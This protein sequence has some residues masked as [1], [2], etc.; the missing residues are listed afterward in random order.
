[1]DE[2]GG[3]VTFLGQVAAWFA[4][5]QHWM[6]D[7]GI[8]HRVAEHLAM[9]AAATATAAL[10]ALP[11]GLVLGHIGRGGAVAI[12][13]SN[14]GRAIPSFAILVFALQVFGIGALPA[15]VA[16]VALA[17]PPILTNAYVGVVE[18]DADLKEA[19]RGL[20]MS[21]PRILF[22]VEVPNA[23]PVIM[24]GIRTSGV[25]V[26]ATATLAALVAWGGLGRFI[27]DGISQRDFVQVFAG[28][29]LV[30]AIA[31]LVEIG[32]A[33]LQWLATPR[34]LRSSI[35]PGEGA[36]AAAVAAQ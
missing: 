9:S 19:A 29:L 3:A 35:S 16:L 32:L 23:I 31:L 12:N 28:A 34:G 27:V 36:A 14:V 17:V 20:G 15:Y 10:I 24:A 4:D 30:A 13:A 2:G 33:G 11:V 22:A 18:V 26:V 6:G 25:Q 8:P 7:Y 21:A 5:G 1:V